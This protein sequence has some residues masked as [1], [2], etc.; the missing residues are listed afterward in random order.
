MPARTSVWL[1]GDFSAHVGAVEQFRS[2]GQCDK[3]DTNENGIYVASLCQSHGM[4]LTNTFHAAGHTWW[5]P[6]GSVSHRLDY[7]L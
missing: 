4:F 1:L 6:Q 5:A 7:F 3:E 2:V